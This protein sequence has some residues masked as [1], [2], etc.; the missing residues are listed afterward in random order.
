MTQYKTPGVYKE[1]VFP[2]P[3]F[4]LLTGVPAFLGF[5]TTGPVN[6]PQR[7]T[8]WSQFVD[9]FGESLT[10]GYL[11]SAVYG[12]FENGG[13]VC[14]VVG[15]D[16]SSAAVA[17]LDRGLAVLDPLEEIDLV[18]APDIMRPPQ[19]G[20]AAQEADVQQMQ[21]A[22][23]SHCERLGD[24]LAILDALPGAP[25][26]TIL[27]QRRGLGGQGISGTNGALYYPWIW[28]LQSTS[29][30]GKERVPP[31]GHIAGVYARSDQRV[32]V[33]KA[34]ANEVLEGVVDVEVNLTAAQQEVLNPEGVNCIRP[35]PGRGIRLWG[36]RTL[37][38]D[39]AWTYIN[40][41]RLFL[42]AGRWIERVMADVAFEP[43]NLLLWIRIE[44]E[45]RA[46]FGE[47]FRQG[48]LRGTA[49]EEAFY[50]H[51]DADTNPPAVRDAGMI[52][53]EIG[54]APTIPSEFVVVRL[55][56]GASGV[57]ITGPERPG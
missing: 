40:V 34:P 51:C 42:T 16:P 35:F 28:I 44:R 4:R 12:F 13:T 20:A 31:C 54:L 50:V 36:A 33:H 45:L 49:E 37:S 15:I 32:G 6:E 53:T 38:V 11:A 56:H 29:P 46:Y 8:V 7:L 43:N 27:A 57:T 9:T 2:A 47:L 41:R 3:E 25:D 52:I 17:A 14:Y 48:A 21:R 22:V 5:A 1:D 39:P 10:N 26:E 30:L 55:I 23:L 18:C 19:A 24:R